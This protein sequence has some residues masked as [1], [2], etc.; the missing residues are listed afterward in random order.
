MVEHVFGKT[1]VLRV[2]VD[3]LQPTAVEPGK[4]MNISG[5]M[6]RV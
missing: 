2:A 4:P 1:G 5:R 6:L 3:E